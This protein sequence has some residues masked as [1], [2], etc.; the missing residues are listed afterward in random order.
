MTTRASP[1][2]GV[3]EGVSGLIRAAV[4]VKRHRYVIQCL[5]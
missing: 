1:A 2:D 5:Y 4:I 3:A